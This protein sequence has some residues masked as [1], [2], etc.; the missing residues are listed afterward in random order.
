MSKSRQFYEISIDGLSI[1]RR[2][3]IHSK[4]YTFRNLRDL[5]RMRQSIPEKI[6]LA[7]REKLGFPLQPT[8]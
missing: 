4:S 8:K 1:K 6:R 2:I 3:G 5:Y 7:T